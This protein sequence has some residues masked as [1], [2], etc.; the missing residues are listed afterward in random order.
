MVRDKWEGGAEY[1]YGVM[2]LC[3]G[4]C[5]VIIINLCNAVCRDDCLSR[6]RSRTPY[7]I[8]CGTKG[9]GHDGIS[10]DFGKIEILSHGK[11]KSSPGKN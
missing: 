8:I 11:M 6:K 3:T 10:S 4:L 7:S 1:V 2:E 9:S 5:I